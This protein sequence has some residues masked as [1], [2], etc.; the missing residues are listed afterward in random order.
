MNDEQLSVKTKKVICSHNLFL[1]MGLFKVFS[2]GWNPDT[3]WNNMIHDE[4]TPIMKKNDRISND[5]TRKMIPDK[6]W[7]SFYRR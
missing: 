7:E 4:K 5:R 1:L 3:H 6:P 2:H